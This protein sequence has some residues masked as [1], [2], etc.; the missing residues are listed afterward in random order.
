MKNSRRILVQKFILF[1]TSV[2]SDNYS[3]A[4]TNYGFYLLPRNTS[5]W[6]F[7]INV[8]TLSKVKG[9]W[10]NEKVLLSQSKTVDVKV[11]I[12]KF[13]LKIRSSH[14]RCSIK[15]AVLKN[16]SIFTGKHLCWS[17]FLIKVQAYSNGCICKN[18]FSFMLR[19]RLRSILKN[20]K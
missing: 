13:V 6:S 5:Y 11:Q 7:L 19:Q 9:K 20:P 2:W 1:T 10:D 15:K 3:F 14:Q 8:S 12:Q 16:C 18:A 17:L 4:D